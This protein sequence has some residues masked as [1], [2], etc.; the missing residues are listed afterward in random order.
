MFEMSQIKSKEHIFTAD[1]I[2]NFFY[3]VLGSPRWEKSGAAPGTE[4]YFLNSWRRKKQIK[5]NN[6]KN[7]GFC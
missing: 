5:K 7:Y 4:R 6:K 3:F 1:Y 2:P